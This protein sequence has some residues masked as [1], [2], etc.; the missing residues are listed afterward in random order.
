[1]HPRFKPFYAGLIEYLPHVLPSEQTTTAWRSVHER[2]ISESGRLVFGYRR[3]SILTVA[4]SGCAAAGLMLALMQVFLWFHER[5]SPVYLL[6]SLACL[7]AA[8]TAMLEL[9]LMFASSTAVYAEILRWENLAVFLLLVSLVWAVYLHLGTGRRWLASVITVLWVVAMVINFTS[10]NSIVFAEIHALKQL[11]TFWNETFVGAVGVRNPWLIVTEIASLLI[12]VF[13]AD[14][15]VRSWR[16]G[17]RRRAVAVGIGAGSFI[18]IGGIHS[19]LVDAGIIETPYMVGFAFLTMVLALSYELVA[20]AVL[21]SRYALEIEASNKRWDALMSN[22][23]L[24]VI[25]INAN[26][27]IEHVNPFFERLSGYSSKELSGQPATRLVPE[28]AAEELKSRLETA[29]KIG[30]RPKGQWTIVCRSGEPRQFMCSTVR[31]ESPDGSYEGVITIAEDITDRLQTERELTAARR[32]ME[33]LLRANMLG[34][35]AS[36]LAHELNQPLAA[37]LSNAQAAQRL[38]GSDALE[39]EELGEILDD[40]VCDDRRASAVISR[41]R[42][43]V[44]KGEAQREP[45]QVNA[46]VHAVIGLMQGELEAHNIHLHLALANELPAVVANQVDMQQVVMNLMMNAVRAVIDRPEESRWIALETMQRNGLIRL[47]VEDSG[48]G[49]TEDAVGRMFE[50]FFTT[51]SSG[52]GMGLAICRRIVEGHGGRIGAENRDA[53][54]ARIS[55]ELPLTQGGQ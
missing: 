26:G 47:A 15:A 19:P 6:T 27:C 13:F 42:S 24:S 29:S 16:R 5:P 7:S 39:P 10:A 8:A 53:G 12:L 36:A 14:A 43:M 9:S 34:E 23:Q 40:I 49:I 22:V 2:G 44:R 46:A 17:R 3:V 20:D 21:A 32:E 18:L 51:K 41:I 28:G 31:Q 30:P 48:A 38:L 45:I 1:V 55:V 54:G 4:W 35:L 37:V 33:R 52:I 25:G 11:P 50:P